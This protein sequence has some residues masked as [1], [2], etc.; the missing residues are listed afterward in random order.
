MPNMKSVIAPDAHV[1]SKKLL[2]I[3]QLAMLI[4]DSGK[5]VPLTDVQGLCTTKHDDD[6]CATEYTPEHHLCNKYTVSLDK[7]VLIAVKTFH[8]H[9]KTRS[10]LEFRTHLIIKS[11]K[12]SL[13]LCFSGFSCCC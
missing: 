11:T 13:P 2:V 10:K 8:K 1:Q 4:W 6:H 12:T 9:H 7:D 5:G 3:F